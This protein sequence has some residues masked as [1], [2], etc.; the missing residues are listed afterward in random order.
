V[1]DVETPIR[2]AGTKRA[3]RDQFLDTRYVLT[4]P[5]VLAGWHRHG[6]A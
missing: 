3:Y 6:G 5:I 2:G 4:V 1:T